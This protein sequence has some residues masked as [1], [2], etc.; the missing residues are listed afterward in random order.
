MTES[1]TSKTLSAICSVA[2]IINKVGLTRGYRVVLAFNIRELAQKPHK[3]HTAFGHCAKFPGFG[4]VFLG[5]CPRT[6]PPTQFLS[7]LN[8]GFRTRLCATPKSRMRFMRLLRKLSINGLVEDATGQ[9]YSVLL[10]DTFPNN[11]IA[12]SWISTGVLFGFKGRL[13]KKKSVPGIILPVQYAPGNLLTA[14][15]RTSLKRGETALHRNRLLSRQK[16]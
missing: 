14:E 7:N 3:P 9:T 10:E 4:S 11:K 1:R 15:K 2:R 5:S 13:F 16:Y 6:L 8:F 12:S